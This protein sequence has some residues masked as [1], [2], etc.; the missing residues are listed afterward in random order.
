M[1]NLRNGL[2]FCHES[3]K[4]KWGYYAHHLFPCLVR[5]DNQERVQLVAASSVQ[6]AVWTESKFEQSNSVG[7]FLCRTHLRA[8]AKQ[9]SIDARIIVVDSTPSLSVAKKKKETT[10]PLSNQHDPQCQKYRESW[11]GIS[12]SIGE[13]KQ[14]PDVLGYTT[15]ELRKTLQA[16]H[17]IGTKQIRFSCPPN[18][19]GTWIS[20]AHDHNSKGAIYIARLELR[21]E[22]HGTFQPPPIQLFDEREKQS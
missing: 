14:S 11:A 22:A 12:R 3:T 16:F 19:H 5:I 18:S 20:S 4:G 8:I 10:Y 6:L 9:S 2:V 7:W 17:E 15:K 21:E 13:E 1:H